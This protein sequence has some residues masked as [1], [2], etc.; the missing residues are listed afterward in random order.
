MNVHISV[1]VKRGVI[2]DNDTCK[3]STMLVGLLFVWLLFYINQFCIYKNSI[4]QKKWN[5]Y[6]EE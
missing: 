2:P 3:I 6:V 1:S 4:I 5:I